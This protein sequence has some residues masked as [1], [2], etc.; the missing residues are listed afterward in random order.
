MQHKTH[1]RSRILGLGSAFPQKVMTNKDIE[2]IVDTSDEWITTRTGIK[3][4]HVLSE[5]EF[6]SDLAVAASLHALKKAGK[7][8]SDVD[9]I[10]CCTTTPDRIMPS[11]AATVQAKLGA[12]PG[13][14]AFDVMTA[15]AGWVTGLQLTDGLVKAGY[16]KCA[17]VIGSEALTRFMNWED[18]ATCVLFGD[19]AGVAVVGPGKPGDPGE[20]IDVRVH[21]DGKNGDHLD[22]PTGGS[23]LPPSRTDVDKSLHYIRMNG[24]EIFKHAVRNMTSVCEEILADQKL[25]IEDIDWFV[26]H[27]ANIRIIEAVGKKL[28]F[29]TEKV[30]LNVHKYGNTSSATIPT[31][32]DEY[33][34]AG[35]I[36]HGQ[37]VLMTTFGGGLSW[38]GALVRW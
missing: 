12:M 19:G 35:K 1:S 16:Y 33:I 38:A 37:L 23:N 9:F 14:A 3:Q 27:Q 36:K 15:C 17:L 20:I 30:A 34:E 11:M 10:V 25:T 21:A 2:K 29:P 31:C 7:S 24:Q 8:P 26:P 32:M 28:N 18:R 22:L 4:R 5:G 13:S 6:N